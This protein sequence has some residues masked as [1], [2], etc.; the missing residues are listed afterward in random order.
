[1]DEIEKIDRFIS[2]SLSEKRYNHC[3]RVAE[4][5]QWLCLKY[6]EDA[7]W[8]ALAG[9][10]HDMCKELGEDAIVSLALRDGKG[11]T[12]MERTKPVLMHGRAAAIQVKEDFGI[13]APAVLEAVREHTVGRPGMGNLAKILYVADKIEPARPQVTEEYLKK[14]EGLDLD[15]LLLYV[16]TENIAFLEQ[17]GKTVAPASRELQNSL[18]QRK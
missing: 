17:K 12:E 8:G 10:A 11:M 2:G 18:K 16:V 6:G 5:A 14:L 1:M 13:E 15:D 9:L 7:E 3:L 4:T